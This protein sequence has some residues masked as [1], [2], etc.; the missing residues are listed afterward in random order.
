MTQQTSEQDRTRGIVSA[1]GIVLLALLGANVGALAA[2]TPATPGTPL[3]GATSGPVAPVT[4]PPVPSPLP[5]TPALP[6]PSPEPLPSPAPAATQAAPDPAPAA[7]VPAVPTDAK[8]RSFS[9]LSTWID[10][11]DVGL[12]PEQQVDIAVAGGVQTIFIETGKFDSKPIE[13]PERVATVIERAHDYGLHVMVWYLPGFVNMQRDY[14]RSLKAMSFVTPRGDRPDSFGLDIEAEELT[15]TAER[16][17][18][19]LQLSA[20]LREWAGPD[21]PMAAIVLPP[22][23]LDLRPSWW[24]EFPYAELAASYDVFIPMSYSSFRGTDARTT[25][26]WNLANV[27]EL[28]RR[29][30]NPALPVH[31]A[32]GIADNLPKV[33]AFVRAAAEA[34]VLGAGLYDLH[35]TQ[36]DDWPVLRRL[37]VEPAG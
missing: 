18:R 29:A 30:G 11:Y 5:A 20:A 16:S 9:G 14:N 8:L 21:Y 23:Q 33:R 27:V 24:P 19:L 3:A 13:H 34:D 7:A 12:T 35:T 28:R 37:R 36:P 32:G 22:L 6:P 26:E 1:I 31:L 2:R 4:P 15:D 10:L 17:R 25:Y